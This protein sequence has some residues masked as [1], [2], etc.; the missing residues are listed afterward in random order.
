[1]SPPINHD[2]HDF[3]KENITKKKPLLCHV[4]RDSIKMGAPGVVTSGVGA[5]SS[6]RM[7]IYR[8][9]LSRHITSRRD[10]SGRD[11]NGETYVR[12]TDEPFSPS[13]TRPLS[14]AAV[15]S[16]R[17]CKLP[18]AHYAASA[19]RIWRLATTTR[20]TTDHIG[21]LISAHNERR[22]GDVR[23]RYTDR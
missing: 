13:C 17:A 4:T 22:A 12:R 6:R 1:M 20:P 7:D 5:S 23:D 15:H 18:I 2:K 14:C 16:S 19:P 21:A 3:A 9:L 10:A 8:N 11:D